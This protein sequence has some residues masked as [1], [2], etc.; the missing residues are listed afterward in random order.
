MGI[1]AGVFFV[2]VWLS[3]YDP[4][5]IR[6]A[7]FILLFIPGSLGL[8]MIQAYFEA[9]GNFRLSNAIVYIPPASTLVALAT[10]ALTHALTP[11]T[12]TLAYYVPTNVVFL[13]R[14]W[15]LRATIS[16]PRRCVSVRA[17]RP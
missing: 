16:L 17:P 12:S 11:F 10:L 15:S 1:V 2:P 4:A 5:S 8:L 3:N 14:L 13:V 9:T 7:Q 6:F